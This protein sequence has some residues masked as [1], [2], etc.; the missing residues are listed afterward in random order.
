LDNLQNCNEKKLELIIQELRPI[1]KQLII[2]APNFG[3]ITLSIIMMD[4]AIK[5][6]ETE[7]AKSILLNEI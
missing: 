1:L 3:K 2:D 4:G 6:L 5:R 7:T